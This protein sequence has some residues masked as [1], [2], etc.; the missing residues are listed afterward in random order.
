MKALE[1]RFKHELMGNRST[2]KSKYVAENISSKKEIQALINLIDSKNDYPIPEAASWCIRHS[3]EHVPEHHTFI[4]EKMVKKIGE[5]ER[6]SL[7]KN[8]LGVIKHSKFPPSI[9]GELAHHCLAYLTQP[10]RS[11]AVLYYSLEI[12]TKICK[13]EPELSRELKLTVDELL[14]ISSNAF[15][16]KYVKT[17]KALKL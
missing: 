15:K 6:D 9:Y 16:R 17:K 10:T 1:D 4:C 5:I 8:L 13:A 3:L 11:K 2:A 7:I 14:P 12:M